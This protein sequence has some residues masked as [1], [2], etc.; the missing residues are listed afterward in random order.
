MMILT[1]TGNTYYLGETVHRQT[2]TPYGTEGTSLLL[3]VSAVAC[4]PIFE[5]QSRIAVCHTWKVLQF[6]GKASSIVT[7]MPAQSQL[8]FCCP[9]NKQTLSNIRKGEE[10][11]AWL[12]IEI[13]CFHI[14]FCFI[15][16]I[17]SAFHKLCDCFL[18]CSTSMSS[19]I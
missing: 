18:I 1:S 12:K 8:S 10:L 16:K 2:H 19:C 7:R 11:C 6:C 5:E 9:Y 14:V 17:V 15:F 3:K 13:L 4:Y